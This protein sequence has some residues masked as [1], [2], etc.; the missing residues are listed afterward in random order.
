MNIFFVGQ[1]GIPGIQAKNAAREQRVEAVATVLAAQGHEVLVACER[2]FTPHTIKRLGNVA[3]LRHFPLYAIWKRQPEVVHMHG[4]LAAGWV[5]VAAILS[6]LSTFVWTVDAVPAKQSRLMCFIAWQA[7][8]AFDVITTPSRQLQWWLRRDFGISAQYV[9]D[10]YAPVLVPM[11]DPK[12]FGLRS[13]KYS[14]VLADNV[15]DL[16]FVAKAYAAAKNTKPLVAWGEDSP[17]WRRLCRQ[18]PFL[19]PLPPL[20][21]R[22]LFSVLGHA[23]LVIFTEH[24]LDTLSL[25]YAMAAGRPM[26]ATASPR[27]IEVLG[28]TAHYIQPKDSRS[29]VNLLRG[30]R[31]GALSLN[32]AAQ[33]R[34]QAHFTWKRIAAEYMGLY[35]SV[36]VPAIALDSA[37]IS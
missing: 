16:R 7:R 25:L 5:R 19:R 28:V 12:H 13:E 30:Y 24:N 1:R 23:S 14:V 21:S 18:Y 29:L 34:A 31:R 10:G 22:G 20:G 15:S 26:I 8:T 32:V 9:P 33:R 27:M 11:I 3:L 35:R 36:T 6:P 17:A 4:W 37:V 2:R